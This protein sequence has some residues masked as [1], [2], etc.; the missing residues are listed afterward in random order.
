VIPAVL[1]F[2][3]GK[4]PTE[5]MDFILNYLNEEKSE[6]FIRVELTKK[7]WTKKEDQDLAFKAVD[8]AISVQQINR[9]G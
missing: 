8:A 1:V 6:D 4:V 3:I 7:G 2:Q 9:E 5:V